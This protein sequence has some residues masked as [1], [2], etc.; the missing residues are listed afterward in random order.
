METID[1]LLKGVLDPTEPIPGLDDGLIEALADCPDDVISKLVFA[2]LAGGIPQAVDERISPF[3]A[4]HRAFEAVTDRFGLE[5]LN[6][7]DLWTVHLPL[8][9]YLIGRRRDAGPCFSVLLVG[10]PGSG[11]TTLARV[12][13]LVL[14]EGFGFPAIAFSSDDFYLD[15]ETRR[16]NGFAWRGP[17]ET[18]DRGALDEVFAGIRAHGRIPRLPRFDT[19]RDRRRAVET[20]SGPLS[21]CIFEGWMAAA[22]LD[23]LPAGTDGGTIDFSIYLDADPAFLKRARFD[24]EEAVRLRSNGE[25]GLP[26]EKMRAFWDEVIEPGIMEYV[27]PFRD[28]AD[29]VLT[30]GPGHRVTAARRK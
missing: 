9:Q 21:F 26:P 30:V 22:L 12:L 13:A 29:L 6:L 3:R 19:G 28:R 20:V 8:A 17:P 1:D 18:H 10:G 2:D 4:A 11:K 23:G 25:K 16:E 5:Y 24:K 27:L 15:R 14:D 7:A